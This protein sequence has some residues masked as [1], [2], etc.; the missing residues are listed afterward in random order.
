MKEGRKCLRAELR[1]EI[2]AGDPSAKLRVMC[3]ISCGVRLG[4]IRFEFQLKRLNN[5]YFALAAVAYRV[6]LL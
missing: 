3:I 1:D 5:K 6:A 4:S 2:R